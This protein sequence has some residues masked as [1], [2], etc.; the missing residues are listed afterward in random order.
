MA[1]KRSSALPAPFQGRWRI[2]EMD[3]W[4]NDALDLVE[5]AF[6]EIKGQEGQMC[7]IAVTAW[8]DIRY[9]AQAGGPIAEFSWE[10]VDEAI[11]DR[12]AAGSRPE[13]PGGS[14]DTSTSTWAT[15]Q[16]SCANLGRF[17]NSLL[18]RRHRPGCPR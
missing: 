8:L 7:F 1:G 12:A 15:I 14:S 5:P 11:N 6:L 18:G 16:A 4:D 2:A 10:G 17:F 13:P 3:L 9:G